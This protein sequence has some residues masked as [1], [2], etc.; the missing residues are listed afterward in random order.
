VGST[1]VASFRAVLMSLIL[2]GPARHR[3]VFIPQIA[4]ANDEARDGH[5]VTG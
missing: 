2:K 4:G 1:V 5:A 3:K